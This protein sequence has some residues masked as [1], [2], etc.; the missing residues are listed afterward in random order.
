MP[1]RRDAQLS[2]VRVEDSEGQD[3][4]DVAPLEVLHLAVEPAQDISRIGGLQRV[5]AQSAPGLPAGPAWIYLIATGSAALLMIAV[6]RLP[7][8][9]VRTGPGWT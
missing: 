8:Q 7:A 4:H 9:F 6:T 2:G 1:G 3:G 5:R